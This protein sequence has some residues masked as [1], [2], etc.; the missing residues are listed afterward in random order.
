MQYKKYSYDKFNLNVIKTDKF[1]TVEAVI[2]FRRKVIKND[3][4]KRRLL[5]LI[6]CESSKKYPIKRLLEME[7]EELYSLDIWND[8]RILGNYDVIEFHVSF[9]NEKYTEIGMNE[10][11]LLFL[12]QLLLNPNI[13]DD[14]FDDWS[15]ELSKKI[16]R[17]NIKT[18]P[19]YPDSYSIKR[20]YETFSKTHPISYRNIG[21]IKDL[22]KINSK[23][24]YEYYLDVMK[25]DIVD[26]SIIGD[27]D[28]KKTVDFFKNNFSRIGS[29]RLSES[30]YNKLMCKKEIELK[31]KAQISQSQLVIGATID[32]N[33]E[34]TRNYVLNV[35]SYI[36]GGGADSLLFKTVREKNSLCY[37]IYSTYNS[38]ADA[39]II[40][41]GIDTTKY[42]KAISLIKECLEKMKKGSFDDEEIEKAKIVFKSSC[43]KCLDSPDSIMYNYI[44]HN[45]MG[46]DLLKDRMKKIDLVTKEMV[47]DLAKKI[48][49]K[50]IYMLES[51][52]EN[53]V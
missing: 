51:E 20:M 23:N 50:I 3:I 34:F 22:N 21:Y 28:I 44:S 19:D 29:N 52:N 42:D 12:L 26:I 14:E 6:L 30:Y 16:V 41:S 43:L 53:R 37:S 38:Y 15:F 33:D 17:D 36:L 11:S 32:I 45:N 31:E 27:I 39:L 4:T 24:L 40:K 35:Y 13:K 9:L 10:K 46:F 5:S 47:I 7:T 48:E 25:N 1:K 49:V 2:Q 18:F 8:A